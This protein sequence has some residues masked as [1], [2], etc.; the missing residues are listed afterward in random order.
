MWLIRQLPPGVLPYILIGMGIFLISIC[1][2]FFQAS[3]RLQ[4]RMAKKDKNR[5]DWTFRKTRLVTL[6]LRRHRFWRDLFRTVGAGFGVF[7]I[8]FG[9]WKLLA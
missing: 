1:T 8:V 2:V 3:E 6:W 7:A 9:L 5:R 4:D